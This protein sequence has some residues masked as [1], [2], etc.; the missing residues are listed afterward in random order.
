MCR[1]NIRLFYMNPL[2]LPERQP[3]HSRIYNRFTFPGNNLNH[4]NFQR[5]H[6]MI[7]GDIG[8]QLNIP[9]PFDADEVVLNVASRR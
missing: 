8:N 7:Y 5:A 6:L 9:R 3:H 2:Y 1:Q 4:F